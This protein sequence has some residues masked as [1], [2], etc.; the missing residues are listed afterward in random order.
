MKKNIFLISSRAITLN[1]FFDIFVKNK[2]FNF[3]LGCFDIKNLKFKNSKIK[4]FLDFQLIKVL[5]PIL[6]LSNLFRNL[7]TIKNFKF[8]TIIV[9]TPLAAFYIRLISFIL[10]KKLIYIVHGFRFHSSER[11]IKSYVFYLYEKLFSFITP[12]YIVLMM[13]IIKLFLKILK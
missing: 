6:I 13:K 5:N 8:D 11:N 3:L 4:L 12:Y 1:N 7:L 2:K 9:N 10:K